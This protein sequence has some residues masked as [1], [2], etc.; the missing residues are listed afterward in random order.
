MKREVIE[1][2]TQYLT[3]NT[4]EVYES[5]SGRGMFGRQTDGIVYDQAEGAIVE[6]ALAV[7]LRD[8]DAEERLHELGI[9]SVKTAGLRYDHMGKN[10]L[11]VY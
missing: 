2:I 4:Y 11:I 8:V 9:T 1:I 10:A 6:Q 7:A 3:Q 5:Y